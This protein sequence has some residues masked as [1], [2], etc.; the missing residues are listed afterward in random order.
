MI[1]K[2]QNGTF[3]EESSKYMMCFTCAK[4]AMAQM[5]SFAFAST[6]GFCDK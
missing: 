3:S 6:V 2:S 1:L 5:R 4:I